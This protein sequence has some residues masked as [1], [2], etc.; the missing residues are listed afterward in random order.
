MKKYIKKFL[1][2]ISNKNL[3]FKRLLFFFIKREFAYGYYKN[4]LSLINRWSWLDNERSNFYYDITDLNKEHLAQTI[5]LVTQTKFD[6]VIPYFEELLNDKYLF[7]HFEKCL[8]EMPSYGTEIKFSYGRRIGWYAF[9]RIL[10]PNLIIETGVDK[11]V[12][13]CVISSALMRNKSEGFIGEYIGTEINPKS[14]KLY[15][16]PY[17]QVG[18]IIYNDSLETL[19]RIDKNIDLF[20]NDSDHSSEYEYREYLEIEKKLSSNSVILGDNSHVTN[21]L[22]KFSRKTNRD[23]IFFDETS[24]TIGILVQV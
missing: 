3:F 23:F 11:G 17:N 1:L 10:K 8:K 16:E 24:K 9:V 15:K 7:N 18:K 21:C 13:S 22:S 19:R 5:A 12:G 2:T 14:G 20:I 4:K 6:E